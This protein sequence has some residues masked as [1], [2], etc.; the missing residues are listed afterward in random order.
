LFGIGEFASSAIRREAELNQVSFEAP[1]GSASDPKEYLAADLHQ[2]LKT[3][4]I[5]LLA[6]VATRA[7]SIACC[8]P[9]G[10]RA[11][12]WHTRK[13]QYDPLA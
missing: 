5:D 9:I 2:F 11:I 12:E 10:A 13:A 3:V 8:S 1:I 7:L 4:R 6:T